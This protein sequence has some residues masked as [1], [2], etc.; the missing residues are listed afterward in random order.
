MKMTEAKALELLNEPMPKLKRG[1][2]FCAVYKQNKSKVEA[3]IFLVS[4]IP[5]YGKR[6]AEVI[7]LLVQVADHACGG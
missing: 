6:I 7:N 2:D 3:A 4:F 1:V 5:V